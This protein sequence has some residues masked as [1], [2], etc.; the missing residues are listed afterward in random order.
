M[1]RLNGLVT[2]AVATLIAGVSTGASAEPGQVRRRSTVVAAEYQPTM[3]QM[4]RSSAGSLYGI[5][6][7][8]SGGPIAGVTVSA[9][10]ETMAFA[11]TDR[12]GRFEFSSLPP[13]QYLLRANHAGFSLPQREYVVVRGSAR[14]VKWLWLHRTTIPTSGDGQPQI[15][16]AGLGGEPTPVEDTP[17]DSESFTAPGD[18]TS[19]HPHT[20]AAWRLRHMRRSVL[21]DSTEIVTITDEGAPIEA[22]DLANTP[23]FASLFGALPFSGEIN[24]LTSGSFNAP[25]ELFGDGMPRGITYVQLGNTSENAAGWAV[26]AA[27]SEGDVSSWILAGSFSARGPRAHAFE[28]GL[29]FGAQE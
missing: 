19:P 27:M 25:G 18:S 10:G 7:D 4:T 26:Q 24:L 21:K 11:V 17:A 23:A 3:P 20:E 15:L 29:S 13:G 9:I 28:T 6:S 12:K 2:T 22:V 16:A 5:V 8:E 14:A 1:K